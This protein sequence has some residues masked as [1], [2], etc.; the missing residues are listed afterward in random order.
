MILSTTPI[1][2]GKTIREYRGIV[3]GEA[4]LGA[5]IFKDLFAGIRDI[6]GCLLYTSPSPR[7]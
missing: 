3:V 2:E 1:L 4:I 7:D 5:N 6:I